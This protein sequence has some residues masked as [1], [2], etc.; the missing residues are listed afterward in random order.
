MEGSCWCDKLEFHRFDFGLRVPGMEMVMRFDDVLDQCID[1]L[2]PVERLEECL[3]QDPEQAGGLERLLQVALA[4]S[5]CA[6]F[7]STT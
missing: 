4:L 6:T 1:R 3:Q 5:F 7:V 2:L